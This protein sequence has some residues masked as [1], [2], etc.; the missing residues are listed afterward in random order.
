MGM[1]K[2]IY[3]KCEQAGDIV[4]N[5][6]LLADIL[7]R[8]NGLQVEI[9]S[10][11]RLNCNIKCGDATF[12]IM[13]MAATDFPE[14]PTVSENNS[15]EIEGKLLAQMKKGTA[16]AA[17]QNE[18]SGVIVSNNSGINTP[19]D[20]NGK[21]VATFSITDYSGSLLIK[22]FIKA[23]EKEYL[24]TLG[25]IKSGV[26]LLVSGKIDYDEYARD[27]CILANSIIKVKRIP[28]MDNYPEK[29]VELHCHS[30]MSAMDA[31]TDPVKLINRAAEWGHQA[32]AITDH[33]C[34]QAFP[35]CMYN[36]PKN[37]KVIY[38]MEAYV[39]NDIDRE[40]ILKKPDDRDFND[41]II[42]FGTKELYVNAGDTISLE[43]L[44]FSRKKAFFYGQL[45][46]IVEP[47]SGVLGA[48][49]V[50]TFEISK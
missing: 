17:A 44:G 50:L 38:G 7:R 27:I 1:K 15:F 47:I 22:C 14:M 12:D 40:L 45:S 29:R 6:R 31:V 32:M 9:S 49:L 30:N 2:E 46:G 18:G 43:E 21:N 5:A 8:M 33:G 10:D 13:G 34:V 24:D 19:A 48:L 42:V 39:V 23:E 16:F 11:D 41:E 36:M 4:I 37:F 3:A 35:D 28:E 25:G 20:L 26:T